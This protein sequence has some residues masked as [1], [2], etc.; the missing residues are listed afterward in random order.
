MHACQKLTNDIINTANSRIV[1]CP[2]AARAAE[3]HVVAFALAF[4]M[5]QL[6]P[7]PAFL[8]RLASRPGLKTCPERSRRVPQSAYPFFA[9]SSPRRSRAPQ[10]RRHCKR[11]TLEALTPSKDRHKVG[12]TRRIRPSMSARRVGAKRRTTFAPP[13][14]IRYRHLRRRRAT[15]EAP[16]P[17]RMSDNVPGSGTNGGS[18]GEPGIGPVPGPDPGPGPPP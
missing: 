6:E 4:R 15:L 11:P 14:T 3:R 17:M 5:I 18:L 10:P 7:E 13:L 12:S 8:P 2:S 9:K 1:N 16:S